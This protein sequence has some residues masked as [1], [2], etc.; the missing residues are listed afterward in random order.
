MDKT[1]LEALI[2]KSMSINEIAK[3]E[4]TS[5]SNVRYWLK[6]FNLKT[7]QQISRFKEI[8]NSKVCAKCKTLKPNDDFYKKTQGHQTNAYCKECTKAAVNDLKRKFKK[9]CIEYK[10]GCCSICNYSK[11][12]TA[13]EFH[14]LDPK[15]K[16]FTI[17]D[18]VT[19]KFT[20][21][22]KLELDKCILVC[23]NC[24]RELHYGGSG[25]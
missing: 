8:P 7:N 14:H 6:K 9:S 16:D 12:D 18:T 25:W 22:I 13:L 2:S 1:K 5:N 17:A 11:C 10:G 21:S 3:E 23:A 20:D 19:Y 4:N 15:E 24:H